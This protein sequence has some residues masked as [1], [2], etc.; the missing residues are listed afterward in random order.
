MING[1]AYLPPLPIISVAIGDDGSILVGPMYLK[2]H[3]INEVH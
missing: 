3:L 1:K 2:P